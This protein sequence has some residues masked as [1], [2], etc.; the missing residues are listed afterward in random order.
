MKQGRQGREAR[1][2]SAGQGEIAAGKASK[3]EQRKCDDRWSREVQDGSHAMVH[4][5][6]EWSDGFPLPLPLPFP[7]DSK[8]T[9]CLTTRC[10][11]PHLPFHMPAPGNTVMP[12][13]LRMRSASGVVGPLAA[14]TTT[15]S[16]WKRCGRG[17]ERRD[18]A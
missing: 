8:P 4:A 16:V 9:A 18:G 3:M 5:A 2:G 14:S 17:V 1:G 12:R 6:A 11:G 7:G 13:S 15:C 10:D